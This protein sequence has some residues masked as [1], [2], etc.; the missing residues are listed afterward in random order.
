M[1][2]SP[3][4]NLAFFR[5][6]LI[7]NGTLVLFVIGLLFSTEATDFFKEWPWLAVAGV[8]LFEAI[9][10]VFILWLQPPAED[11]PEFFADPEKTKTVMRFAKSSDNEST[12]SVYEEWFKQSL[13]IADCEYR[14]I[15][16]RGQFVRVAEVTKKHTRGHSIFVSGYYAVF[17]I[18][19][20]L[21]NDL[22]SGNKKE[23]DIVS[24]DVLDIFDPAARVLYICEAVSSRKCSV[25][26]E[27][28]GD[29]LSY[30]AHIV[31]QNLNITT[32]STWP[33]TKY[34][35]I[36]VKKRK[37]RKIKTRVFGSSY[38]EL[39]VGAFSSKGIRKFKDTH[40]INYS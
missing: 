36:A 40:A 33:Y 21:L 28:M 16:A 35:V 8:V 18:T 15:T 34:G 7:A 3:A 2:Q 12:E 22:Y 1:F 11:D 39:P 38:Y 32:I 4:Y 6:F 27:L 17:P 26:H 23:K 13:S 19:Q 31:S 29:L 10:F 5:K 9:V 24:S 20:E 14:K 25:R 37:F 30:C